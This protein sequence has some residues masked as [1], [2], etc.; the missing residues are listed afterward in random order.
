MR[1]GIDKRA[2]TLWDKSNKSYINYQNYL[3]RKEDKFRLTMVDLLCIS[4]FKGGFGS[5]HEEEK[6]VRRKLIAY[7]KVLVEIDARFGGRELW[8]LSEEQCDELIGLIKRACDLTKMKTSTKID[9]IGVSYLSALLNAYFPK[10]IPIIDRRILINMKLVAQK[11]VRYGQIV[12]IE[13]FY[14]PLVKR[15]ATI[16]RE[17]GT[18]IREIDEAYFKRK[19]N[20]EGLK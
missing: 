12:D 19:L 14:E 20:V 13:N 8:E 2:T 10:L 1:T 7:S 4:N 16:W 15:V 3:E 6:E 9:G 11:D 18:D 17:S 5:I